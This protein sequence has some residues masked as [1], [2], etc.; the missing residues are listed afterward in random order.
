[1][2]ATRTAAYAVRHCALP[3]PGAGRAHITMRTFE[4]GEVLPP[5]ADQA[6][7]DRLIESGHVRRITIPNT[8][9]EKS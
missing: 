7:V 6:E 1:M 9:Q 4:P 2:A 3:F 8:Q 5:D